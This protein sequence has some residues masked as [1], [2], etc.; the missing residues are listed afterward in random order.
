M[1]RAGR[2][3]ALAAAG[4]VLAVVLGMAALVAWSS[5]GAAGDLP[6]IPLAADKTLGVNAD[7]VA[8]DPVGQE[9]ALAA[10]EAA[11]L[12][13]LRVRFAWDASEPAPGVHDWTAW[14]AVVDGA[15]QHDLTL[16]AVLDGSPAWAR[17][18]E[19][20]TNPL[21]PP[22]EVRDFGDWAA[23]LAAR[24]GDRIDHYQ[25]WDE[26]NIAPHWGGREIDPAGY[27]RLLREG[28]VR[29][30]AADPGALVLAAALA[31]NIEAGGA[32]MSELHFLDTLYGL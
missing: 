11:G 26:P 10:M 6:W 2:R 14:D 16:I 18:P 3:L 9:A 28:A 29:V 32:N 23:V 12:R 31:P 15:M 7:L 5:A 22:A 19:D 30:R 25:I 13:W 20:A 27:L 17:A 4:L 21:A 8:L 1:D 24:Y